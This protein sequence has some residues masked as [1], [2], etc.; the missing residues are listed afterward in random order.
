MVAAAFKQ[1]S[2]EV[3]KFN[4]GIEKIFLQYAGEL[5][6]EAQKEKKLLDYYRTVVKPSVVIA[7]K[8]ETGIQVSGLNV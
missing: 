6:N 4:R 7:E 3:A 2:K 8:T 1:G 5:E